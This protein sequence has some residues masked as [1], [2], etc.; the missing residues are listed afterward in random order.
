MKRTVVVVE[1]DTGL[2]EQLA[3]ILKT[4]PDIA[5][6]GAYASAED[7]LP[8][9]AHLQPN[10]VL[11]DIKLPGMSG[12][13]CV[14]EIKKMPQSSQV[15]M[16]TVY[17][18]SDSIFGA[19]KAGADGYIIK[20]D[21]PDQLLNAIRNVSDGGGSM[22]IPI[23][24]KVIQHFHLIGA[25]TDETENLSPREREVLD[26][27]AQGYI[28]KEIGCMLTIGVATVRTHVQ[29]ICHKMHVRSRVEAVAKHQKSKRH[30]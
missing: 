14:A 11:M 12:T 5:F 10:V 3:K 6:V 17:E 24:R 30:P 7:A 23:A 28:Y 1:D 8:K 25:S 2:R 9:I 13:Q 15:I 22:S 21:S 29:H 26:L 4:A 18:D 19:L 27:L 20:S 16:V